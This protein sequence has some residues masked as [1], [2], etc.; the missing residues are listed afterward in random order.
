MFRTSCV[1]ILTNWNN[2]V[3]YTGVTSNLGQRVQEFSSF[4]MPVG[5]RT[6]PGSPLT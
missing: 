1:H 5:R 6:S 2:R 3:I 4:E